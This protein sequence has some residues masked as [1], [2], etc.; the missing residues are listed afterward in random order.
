[1]LLPLLFSG[2]PWVYVRIRPG[3]AP[4]Y[5]QPHVEEYCYTVL[6][7]STARPAADVELCCAYYGLGPYT[8]SELLKSVTHANTGAR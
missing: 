4:I 6:Q 5:F 2:N 1:M 8:S 7:L 3:A